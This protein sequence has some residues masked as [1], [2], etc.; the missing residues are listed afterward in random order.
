MGAHHRSTPNLSTRDLYADYANA[1]VLLNAIRARPESMC[2]TES[3]ATFRVH[4]LRSEQS[5]EP[6]ESPYEDVVVRRSVSPA[7]APAPAPSTRDALTVSY[8]NLL[9]AEAQDTGDGEAAAAAAPLR[10]PRDERRQMLESRLAEGDLSA[11]LAAVPQRDSSKNCLAGSSE[12]NHERNFGSEEVLPYDETRV[13][14]RPTAANPSGYCNASHVRVR[15]RGRQLSHI[16]AQS[17]HTD[18]SVSEF[19]RMVWQLEVRVLAQLEERPVKY[20]PREVGPAGAL[21]F[22]VRTFFSPLPA[23]LILCLVGLECDSET[24]A[25]AVAHWQLQHRVSAP[26]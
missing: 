21:S 1:E 15:V 7:P 18:S 6:L 12:E 17:P 10:I 24:P 26:G 13:K 4:A 20:W 5:C 23:P 25:A 9:W 2:S 14:L 16:A 22:Q 11:E 8:A 3:S 19:W